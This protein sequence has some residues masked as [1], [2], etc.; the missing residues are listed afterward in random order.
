MRGRTHRPD[1]GPTRSEWECVA[2]GCFTE[3]DEAYCWSCGADEDGTIPP[4]D[5][6]R[7]LMEVAGHPK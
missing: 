3:E 4:D 7:P 6:E 5:D 2:C 1:D